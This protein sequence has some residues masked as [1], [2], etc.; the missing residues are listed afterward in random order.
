MGLLGA[1][2]HQAEILLVKLAKVSPFLGATTSPGSFLQAAPPFLPVV[3]GGE[4]D[5][6][7]ATHLGHSKTE[8]R[9]EAAGWCFSLL[10][11]NSAS[12]PFA[13]G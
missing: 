10:F 11:K 13:K 9:Q 6:T 12:L 3:A 2:A 1:R 8:K 5:G 7:S 4:M